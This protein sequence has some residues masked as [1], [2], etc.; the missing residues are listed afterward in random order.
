MILAV[1]DFTVDRIAIDM[2]VERTHED[3]HLQPAVIEIFVVVHLFDHDHFAIG[4]GN[5]CPGILRVVPGRDPEKGYDKYK[6]R[7]RQ[8]GQQPG[9]PGQA[10]TEKMETCK[11][12]G[13]AE[14]KYD[15]DA[16][17]SFLVNGHAVKV[18][19]FRTSCSSMQG[20]SE[21]TDG[22]SVHHGP[23]ILIRETPG[24]QEAGDPGDVRD[25]FY[26]RR[27]LFASITAIQV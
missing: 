5:D 23:D 27:T 9:H 24:A 25:R 12:Q 1:E 11:G 7:K 13:A 26:I 16:G 22:I 21:E 15:E 10:V 19:R 6:K 20:V 2:Y 3:G 17:S 18:R 14:G 4:R 8:Q